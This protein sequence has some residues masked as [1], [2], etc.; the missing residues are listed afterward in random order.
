MKSFR[1]L[2]LCLLA[3]LGSSCGLLELPKTPEDINLTNPMRIA[4]K[5][6]V[7]DKKWTSSVSGKDTFRWSSFTFTGNV[8]MYAVKNVTYSEGLPVK[9]QDTYY[10]PTKYQTVDANSNEALYIYYDYKVAD[11]GQ[12]PWRCVL[13]R[14]YETTDLS[15]SD[16]EVLLK[17]WGLSRLNY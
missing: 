9:E 10:G 12:N 6:P 7:I 1:L 8:A 2:W 3:I 11:A 14:G 15:L 4:R 13:E 16:A 17:S 5:L